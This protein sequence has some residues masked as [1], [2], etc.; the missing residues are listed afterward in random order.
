MTVDLSTFLIL[1]LVFLGIAYRHRKS[2]AETDQFHI[3][4]WSASAFAV[5][6]SVVALF[7]AGE[8]ATFTDL[9]SLVGSGI[10]V[11]FLGATSGFICMYFLSDRFFTETR[12]LRRKD[13]TLKTAY[14][15]NDVVFERY[16]MTAMVLFT[17]LAALSL[18]ALYLIQVIVGSELI[19]AGSGVSYEWAVVGVSLFVAAYVITSGLE[20]IYSTDKI[21]VAALFTALL[22]ISYGAV[23]DFDVNIIRE[24]SNTFTDLLPI[25][26]PVGARESAGLGW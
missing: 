22:F 20:G 11:F 18:A 10:L 5:V 19:A 17:F 13:G 23:T 9:Y 21:Q 15:I 1:A 2:T 25:V 14:H 4:N 26:H 16:G 12:D 8:I 6:A 24:Y 3:A 7:G